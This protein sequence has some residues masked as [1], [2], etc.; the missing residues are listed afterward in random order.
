MN[1]PTKEVLKYT[2]SYNYKKAR[3]KKRRTQTSP[4]FH[5]LSELTYAN[6]PAISILSF[7]AAAPAASA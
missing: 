3:H 5:L 2:F 4:P 1:I 7:S 6:A